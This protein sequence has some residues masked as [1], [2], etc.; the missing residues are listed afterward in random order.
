MAPP[1]LLLILLFHS[2]AMAAAATDA[3]ILHR[4]KVD[5]ILDPAGRLADWTTAGGVA[6]SPCNWT[7]VGCDASSGSVTS[8]DLSSLGLSGDFPSAFC[9][10]PTLKNLTLAG[11]DFAGG[12]PSAALSPCSA[13]YLIDLSSN[14]FTGPLPE[15]PPSFSELVVLDLSQNNFSGEIP[16]SFGRFPKLQVLNL[17]A[18]L[19]NGTLPG[20]LTNLTELREFNLAYN[21]FA[22]SRLPPDLG[23][24]T[25]L[26]N[27]WLPFSNL[28]GEI[29]ESVGNLSELTNLDLSDNYISGWIPASVGHLKSILQ[30]ALY[31]NRISGELPESIGNLSTLLR[32]DVS[33]NNL[34]GKLPEKIA[35][36]RLEALGLND[37]KLEGEVPAVL[38]E[39]PNLI[40]LKLF[41]NRF[42]GTI[43]TDLG[44]HSLIEQIDVSG[45]KFDGE[46]PPAIC[47]RGRLQ[48]L[49]AFANNLSGQ[50][51]AALG[52]CQSLIYVRIFNND[53]TGELPE[54]VW[55]LPKLYYMDISSNR[56]GG[57]IP[58]TIAGAQNLTRFLIANNSFSG[59]V[60]PQ[61]CALSR[62]S[63]IEGSGNGLSGEL[64]PCVTELRM[65]E[66]LDL[67]GNQLSGKI[68]AN[69]GSWRVLT[70][71]N[72]SKNRFFGAIPHQLG[73]LPQLTYL[74]L[75]DN[76]LSGEIPA[77]L[78]SLKLNSFNLSGNDLAGKVPAGLDET[79]YLPSLLRNPGLC[80]PDLPPLPHCLP[81]KTPALTGH[82]KV[83]IS[84][85]AALL[86][87]AAVAAIS[88]AAFRLRPAF[89]DGK[90]AQL[91][92]LTS[93]QRPASGG[94]IADESEI[95]ACLTDDN[96]IGEGGAGR[97]YKAKLKSGQ[98]VAVKKIHRPTISAAAAAGFEAEVDILGKVRHG[99]IVKLLCCL[100][101][102][103][104]KV[105]VYEYMV[106]G[107][108]KEALHCGAGE[109]VAE[110]G[111]A[112]RR[113]IAVGAAQGVAYLHHDCVPPIVHRDVKSANILLDADFR[114]RV[115]DFGL[116]RVI[117]DSKRSMSCVAGSYGY[118]APGELH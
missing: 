17:F 90:P 28:V 85:A 59:E 93:F 71:L 69:V 26:T 38:A 66:K 111:W 62:L 50:F 67:S 97:V 86:I 20:F 27:L 73:S 76:Q 23:K 54:K 89:P 32:F 18:N 61:L 74:D 100:S 109:G 81:K 35:A 5:G 36:L 77:S 117:G 118:I 64:P 46:L 34:I 52:E 92:K 83:V 58:S 105:L 19:L 9:R 84:L 82:A 107:S 43:P 94:N 101:G 16:A 65:L 22:P 11:N 7:G 91:C 31:R 80:S 106:N 75:S 12:L 99:N 115:A 3:E 114:A 55:G 29:P 87:L 14:C 56:F 63:A 53:L 72:F 104:F 37:N 15:L 40:D 42:S 49:V 98:T 2:A 21:P 4:A 10:I 95:L 110:M 45:N 88:L 113:Q 108:L 24:M 96:I 33:E 57:A 78:A 68:P 30:I 116:A 70:E 103:G 60:P 13:V 1:L 48:R 25:K 8:L 47:R 41:N 6:V 44:R 102:E 112:R 51:P 39:N 79:V